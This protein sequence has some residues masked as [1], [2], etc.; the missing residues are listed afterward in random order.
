LKCKNFR[1]I[2]QEIDRKQF[3]FTRKKQE[4]EKILHSKWALIIIIFDY[5]FSPGL[6]MLISLLDV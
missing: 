1:E 4:T 2:I 5:S 6:C 3:I